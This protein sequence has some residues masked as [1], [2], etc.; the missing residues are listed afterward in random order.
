MK[1]AAGVIIVALLLLILEEDISSEFIASGL[2]F[3]HMP[4]SKAQKLR[5]SLNKLC[6][7]P[8]FSFTAID[9][10]ICR[11]Q[12]HGIGTD[13]RTVTLTL[14]DGTPCGRQGEKCKKG[15]CVAEE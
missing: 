9:F 7:F 6:G 11:Y 10:R 14:D 8:R 15:H 2:P 3:T 12:C 5:A 4:S 1:L 13:R